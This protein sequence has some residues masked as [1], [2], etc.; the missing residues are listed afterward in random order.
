MEIDY[1]WFGTSARFSVGDAALLVRGVITFKLAVWALMLLSSSSSECNSW[2][3]NWKHHILMNFIHIQFDSIR[4]RYLFDFIIN[5]FIVSYI[6]SEFLCT[7]H[8][9][10][11]LGG[12][13]HCTFDCNIKYFCNRFHR[14][15]G[16]K[17]MLDQCIQ[18]EWLQWPLNLLA[19]FHFYEK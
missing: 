18:V 5:W 1:D 9:G 3:D 4:V 17:C 12:Q 15:I 14:I 16:H 13:I 8:E 19:W 10:S 11:T 7:F 6:G 2:V